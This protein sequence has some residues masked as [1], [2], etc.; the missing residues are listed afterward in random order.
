MFGPG[1]AKTPSAGLFEAR[2]SEVHE[3]PSRSPGSGGLK[4]GEQSLKCGFAA[5]G[6]EEPDFQSL[7]AIK[8]DEDSDHASMAQ[9][10]S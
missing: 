8:M 10:V 7:S 4:M 3:D 9:I 5:E 6:R 1:P 2:K